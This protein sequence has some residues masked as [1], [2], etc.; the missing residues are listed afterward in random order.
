M[1]R[2][3]CVFHT[4]AVSESK[5][6]REMLCFTIETAVCAKVG[7]VRRRVRLCSPSVG[8]ILHWEAQSQVVKRIVKVGFRWCRLGDG[9]AVLG[10]SARR[11]LQIAL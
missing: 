9:G 7:G 3:C 5:I 11:E 6:A 1:C 10:G 2:K 8:S 4:K